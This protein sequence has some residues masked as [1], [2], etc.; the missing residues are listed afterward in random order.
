VKRFDYLKDP[1][2][3]GMYDANRMARRTGSR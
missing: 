3:S 2:F 1:L